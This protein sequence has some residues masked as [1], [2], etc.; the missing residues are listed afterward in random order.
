MAQ[1][2]VIKALDLPAFLLLLFLSLLWGGSFFFVEVALTAFSPLT[3]VALRVSLAAVILWL[4]VV[5]RRMPVPRSAGIWAAF[6]VM[7][8]ANNAIP[9][10][11][12]VWGQTTISSGLAAVL[13]ATTPFFT[14]LLAGLLLPDERLTLRK[15]LGVAVGLSGVAVMIGPTALQGLGGALW[16]Q[17]AILGGTFSY[18]CASVFGRRFAAMGVRPTVTAAGQVTMSSLLLLPL[19]LK[20]DGSFGQS[21]PGWGPVL[22]I[23][24]IA[25]LSTALAFIIYFHLLSTVGATNLVLVTFLIPISAIILGLLFLGEA[26]TAPQ[27]MGMAI[28]GIGL[29]L[30]D[31]RLYRRQKVV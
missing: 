22:S 7:G 21:V 11:L 3:I 29:S 19:A 4:W 5:L 26:L 6:A 14:I 31:G 30:I 25:S 20:V 24:G 16:G 17:I 8:V 10:I 18:A 23:I 9:F 15:L 12:I 13:N 2:P 1:A 28:I 27:I